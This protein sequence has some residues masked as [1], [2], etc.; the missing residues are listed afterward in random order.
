MKKINAVVF[1]RFRNNDHFQFM[2]DF[3]ALVSRTTP[4]ALNIENLNTEFNEAFTSLNNVF[5]V[6]EG[7]VLTV[8]IGGADEDRDRFW[9]ALSMRIRATQMGPIEEEVEAAGVLQ[10]VFDLYGNVRQLSLP[11]E[12][13]AL[14][15]LVED[16]EQEDNAALCNI[17]GVTNW[18]AA[19]K[20]QNTLVQSYMQER[21][22]ENAQKI[23]GSVKAA[24]EVI[25]PVYEKIVS[26]INALVELDMST[27]E[28]TEFVV[29]LNKQIKEFEELLAMRQGHRNSDEDRP[30]PPTPQ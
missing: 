30:V 18:V 29:L 24:R 3:K 2:T 14:S 17:V 21:R 11:E 5:K 6:D 10:R 12:S 15:N 23:S 7:S 20:E 8:A 16:L 26:R 28:I 1:S 25:D 13:A 9:S 27:P 19:L 4:V 22:L